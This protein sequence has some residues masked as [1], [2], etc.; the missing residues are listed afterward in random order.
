MGRKGSQRSAELIQRLVEI[1]MRV[2][3]DEL[4]VPEQQARQA[5]REIAHRLANEYGGEFMYVPKDREFVL[6]RRDLQI[7]E[8]LDRGSSVHD[9]ARENGLTARQ[10]Y[11]VVQHARR[12]L[13]A[14]R[15]NPL[16]GF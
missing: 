4:G 15:Q 2:I 8:R 13:Q 6:E 14:K 7:L 9:V 10:V 5:M 1:G 12:H 16:P 11:S 3:V